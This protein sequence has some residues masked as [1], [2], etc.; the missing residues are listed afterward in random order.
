[1]SGGL[2]AVQG[3]SLSIRSIEELDGIE[4]CSSYSDGGQ[5]IVPGVIPGCIPGVGAWVTG[6]VAGGAGARLG[7]SGV[8]GRLSADEG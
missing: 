5:T 1:M 6:T 4:D 7:W 3:S 2:K 8:G